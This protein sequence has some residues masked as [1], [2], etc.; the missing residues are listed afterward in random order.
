MPKRCRKC[1]GL[2]STD[3]E[4][5][6]HCGA[7]FPAAKPRRGRIGAWI[8]AALGIFGFFWLISN[9]EQPS[10]GSTDKATTSTSSSLPPQSARP[11]SDLPDERICRNALT[12]SK[13]VWE[14]DSWDQNPSYAEYVAEAR[15]RDFTVDTCRQKLRLSSAPPSNP[16][17]NGEQPS[18]GS[19]DK[20]TASTSSSAPQSSA[21]PFSDL[22]E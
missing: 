17:S 5:C 1:G 3:A 6:H 16:P 7:R 21:R 12:G 14:Q 10:T 9:A 2:V 18:T 19:T 22:P 8:V 4:V 13:T 11:V 20:A 15:R